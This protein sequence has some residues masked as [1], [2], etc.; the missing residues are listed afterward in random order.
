MR[1]HVLRL[2]SAVPEYDIQLRVEEPG[3][4]ANSR[5]SAAFARGGKTTSSAKRAT[6]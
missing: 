1:E 2:R 5:K 3:E 6:S 4:G